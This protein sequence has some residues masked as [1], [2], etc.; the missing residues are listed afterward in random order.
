MT[1]SI[2]GEKTIL[3][4]VCCDQLMN[5]L[6]VEGVVVELARG[7]V[8]IIHPGDVAVLQFERTLSA[9]DADD[10]RQHWERN[11]PG[12]RVIILGAGAKVGAVV[13][14]NDDDPTIVRGDA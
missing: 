12:T 4:L 5:E 7:E 13:R 1:C 10:I 3:G 14:A 6:D 8:A 11:A 2:C 9:S